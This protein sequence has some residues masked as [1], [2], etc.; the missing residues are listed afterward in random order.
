MKAITSII[1]A[2]FILTGCMTANMLEAERSYYQAAV[3]L[4][5]LDVPFAGKNVYDQTKKKKLQNM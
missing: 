5:E 3:Q 4:Q 1:L 2:T